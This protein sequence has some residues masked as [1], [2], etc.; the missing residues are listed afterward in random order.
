MRG[1][2]REREG[3][4]KGDKRRR[5]DRGEEKGYRGGKCRGLSNTANVN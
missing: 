2:E 3:E 5:E 4:G 1:R